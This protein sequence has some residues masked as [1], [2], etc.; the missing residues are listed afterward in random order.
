LQGR[1]KVI[2]GWLADGAVI[3]V[4]SLEALMGSYIVSICAGIFWP[5]IPILA[6]YGIVGDSKRTTVIITAVV[7]S[8]A[9]GLVS[10]NQAVVFSGLALS[11]FCAIV[12][13][14][15][16]MGMSAVHPYSLFSRCGLFIAQMAIYTFSFCYLVER[17]ARHVV[18]GEPFVEI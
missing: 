4:G 8:A 15:E 5:L 9:I 2:D 3:E 1:L 10:R 11:T 13:G 16:E 18:E 7:Y 14:A 12:Y 6:E 17:F